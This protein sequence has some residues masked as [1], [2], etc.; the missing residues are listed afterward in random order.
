M[1]KYSL[2]ASSDT[3]CC[4]IGCSYDGFTESVVIVV[5]GVVTAGESVVVAGTLTI[6]CTVVVA[7]AAGVEATGVVVTP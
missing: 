2:F 1:T 3:C 4:A 7:T 6:P 5:V